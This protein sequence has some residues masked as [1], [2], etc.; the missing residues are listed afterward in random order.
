M[1][2]KITKHIPA[3]L[4]VISVV[5]LTVIVT[6]AIFIR[7]NIYHQATK[8]EANMT[9]SVSRNNINLLLREIGRYK[10]Y[11][12]LYAFFYS[13]NATNKNT[14]ELSQLDSTII[15]SWLILKQRVETQAEGDILAL[16]ESQ[17]AFNTPSEQPGF[18][19]HQLDQQPLL[20]AQ[21][22]LNDSTEVG[23]AINLYA[24]HDNISENKGFLSGYITILDDQK[25]CIYHPDEKMIG[26]KWANAS[27]SLPIE[28][29][30]LLKKNVLSSSYSEFLNMVLQKY[31]VPAPNGWMVI[32]SIPNL[33]YREFI[34][35]TERN[36][37][38]LT[39][40]P[41]LIILS[42]TTI[43]FHNW[44]KTKLQKSELGKAN[45]QLQLVNEQQSKATA[46]TELETLK[47]NLNPH[48]LFNSLSSLIALIKREPLKAIE[49]T[50]A[51]SELYRYMLN[52]EKQSIT[53][54]EKEMSFTLNFI[55]IQN[56]RYNGYITLEADIPKTFLNRELPPISIQAMVENCIK[57]NVISAH[58]PLTIHIYCKQ[59]YLC[60]KNNL[61]PSPQPP[62]GTS[63]GQRNL[64]TRY[65][66][67][68]NLPCLFTEQESFYLVE[69]PIITPGN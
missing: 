30:L 9:V 45:L 59:G 26:K 1:A 52:H 36:T 34:Q 46:A 61:N 2:F 29:A 50:R 62:T 48:F 43:I 17:K 68:T 57:H 32:S 24:F 10:D 49:F 6:P 25:R 37:L 63:F 11:L 12:D 19:F 31:Y 44:Q 41:L 13:G 54:V 69:I 5:L 51:L 16:I 53:T 35:Q 42:T 21:M 33:E 56:I 22:R 23:C 8:Q 14:W 4:V 47:Q 38:M 67:I 40:L 18:T 39:L 55:K 28:E 20:F 64:Q 7:K 15:T 66:A 3:K 65:R 27:D 58:Q 60:I